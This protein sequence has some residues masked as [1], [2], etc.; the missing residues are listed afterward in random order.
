MPGASEGTPSGTTGKH[1]TERVAGLPFSVNGQRS[2]Y[3]QFLI[4]GFMA[5]EVQSGTAAVSPIIDSLM[6]FRVQSSNYSAQF[7][8]EA[9]GQ[10]NTVLRSG[11]NDLHGTVWEYLRNDAFD[12]NDFFSNLSGRANGEYRRNQFGAAAGGPV[13]LPKYDGRNRTFIYGAFEDTRVIQGVTPTLTTVPTANQRQGIFTSAI[14]DPLNGM[15]FPNNQ[16]PASRISSINNTILQ[17]W[18]PLPNNGAGNLNWYANYPSTLY[19][20]YSNWRIDQRISSKDSIF[21]HYLFND[22]NYNWAKTFPTDGTTDDTR[23]QNV[24]VHWTHIFGPRMLND[25]HAGYSRFYETE[26]EIREGKE[27]VVRELGMVGLCE[28]P[29]CWGIPQ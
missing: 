21:G 12:S 10:V 22:T 13:I 9:G 25:L 8:T 29:S 28:M 23:G 6:E 5:K 20:L 17:K 7:G 19:G 26:F 27:D 16:I 18:V 11:T 14:K 3:N 15:A 2:N 1:Y 4:D 24:V